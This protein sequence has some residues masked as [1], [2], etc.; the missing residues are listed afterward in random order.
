MFDG[1]PNGS[2]ML[3]GVKSCCNKHPTKMMLLD[4]T[5]LDGVVTLKT[6]WPNERNIGCNNVGSNVAFVGHS[7]FSVTT[8]SSNVAPSIQQNEH[9]HFVGCLLQH[10]LTPNNM[11]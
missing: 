7:V 10:D 1:W 6:G 3:F 11:L 9:V 8:P 2:N 5:L 4:A